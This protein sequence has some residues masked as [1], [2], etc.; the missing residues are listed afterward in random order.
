[1]GVEDEMLIADIKKLQ[2]TDQI[3]VAKELLSNDGWL[4]YLLWIEGKINES[5]KRHDKIQ[6]R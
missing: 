5:E 1:M 3:E 4:F 2:F 6:E